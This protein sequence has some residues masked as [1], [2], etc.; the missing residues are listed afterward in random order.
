MTVTGVESIEATILRLAREACA[1][2]P[3]FAQESVVLR[4][5]QQE[6]KPQSLEDQQKILSVWH[7]LF[8]EGKLAWGY[9]LANPGSPF[10]HMP[11]ED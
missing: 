9:N 5:A 1:K 2:G 10:F 6:L 3:G 7:R 4:E 11:V 8:A